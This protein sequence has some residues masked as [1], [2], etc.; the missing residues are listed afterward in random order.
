MRFISL[1]VALVGTAEL[2]PLLAQSDSML[3]C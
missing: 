1:N 3:A 2:L